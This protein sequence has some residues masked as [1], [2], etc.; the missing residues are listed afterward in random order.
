LNDPHNHA[1]PVLDY[2]TKDDD[3]FLVMPLLR[4]F[5]DPPFGT[6]EEVVDFVRQMLQVIQKQRNRRD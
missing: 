1:V 6:V 5:D 3:G 2:F 4:K